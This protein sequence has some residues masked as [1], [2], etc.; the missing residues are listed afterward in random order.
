VRVFPVPYMCVLLHLQHSEAFYQAPRDG[1]A[2]SQLHSK[3]TGTTE[4][5]NFPPLG[6]EAEFCW[7]YP[8]LSLIN[9]SIEIQFGY[10]SVEVNQDEH[11]DSQCLSFVASCSVGKKELAELL[12][13]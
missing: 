11:V 8:L 6:N 3:P 10:C 13:A 2:G 4:M 5:L 7:G 12:A 9:I 1:S